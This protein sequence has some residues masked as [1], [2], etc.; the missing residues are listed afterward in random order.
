[1]VSLLIVVAGAHQGKDALVDVV[2][3]VIATAGAAELLAAI[4]PGA[5][6]RLPISEPIMFLAA[7]VVAWLVIG[8]LPSPDPVGNGLF[9]EHLTE[10]CASSR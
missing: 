10:L 4:L 2:P 1:M 7:G 3:W 9:T 8:D 5:L 6:R